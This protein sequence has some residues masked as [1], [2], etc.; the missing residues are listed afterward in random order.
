[1]RKKIDDYVCGDLVN[2]VIFIRHTSK[3]SMRKAIFLCQICNQENEKRFD[4]VKSGGQ[5]YCKKCACKIMRSARDVDNRKCTL[6]A[7]K[8]EAYRSIKKGA[9]GRNKSFKLSYDFVINEIIKSCNYCGSKPNQ[10]KKNKTYTFYHHGLDRVNNKL[11]YLESNV[12]SCCTTCN[13]GKSNLTLTE[14]QS[15]IKQLINFNNGK[16]ITLF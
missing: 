9:I 1:M 2:G 16:G 10:L 6:L 12:V 13:K 4:H 11:G 15:Y 5:K 3:G 8:K 7:L 14:W